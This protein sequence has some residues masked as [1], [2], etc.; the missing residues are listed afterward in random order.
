[1]NFRE[2]LNKIAESLVRDDA[3]IKKH[4]EFF[5][6]GI[7]QALMQHKYIFNGLISNNIYVAYNPTRIYAKYSENHTC[8]LFELNTPKAPEIFLS[9]K[10]DFKSQGFEINNEKEKSFVVRLFN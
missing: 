2:E 9:L 8:D 3:N 7:V 10:E 5:E 1:M 4:V 6:K